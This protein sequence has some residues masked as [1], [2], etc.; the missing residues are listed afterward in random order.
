MKTSDFPQHIWPTQGIYY[1]LK[2]TT[3]WKRHYAF[4]NAQ[5]AA[6]TALAWDREGATVYHAL[7]SY[8][9][10]YAMRQDPLKSGSE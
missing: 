4:T 5:S 6:A 2:A 3:E 7:A 10:E 8:Q 9:K 1:L